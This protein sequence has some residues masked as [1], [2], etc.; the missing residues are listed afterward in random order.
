MSV[1]I[2]LYNSHKLNLKQQELQESTRE[3]LRIK[4]AEMLLKQWLMSLD[5]Y[6]NNRQAYIYDSLVDQGEAIIFL[7]NQFKYKYRLRDLNEKI[8]AVL[9]LCS[10]VH[11]PGKKKRNENDWYHIITKSDTITEDLYA[12]L[13]LYKADLVLKIDREKIKIASRQITLKRTLYIC[14]TALIVFTFLM[15]KWSNRTIV[16]P[17]KLLRVLA[18]KEEISTENFPYNNPI[19]LKSLADTLKQYVHD[20]EK[21]KEL[22]WL[23]TKQ[24]E[25]INMRISSIMET[26][27]DAIICSKAS[28]QIF[29]MNASFRDLVNIEQN[30]SSKVYLCQDFISDINLQK[31][32]VHFDNKKVLPE[33]NILSGLNGEKIKIELSVSK[34][35]IDENVFY[36]IIIRDV[37]ERERMQAQLLQS[38]KMDSIGILASGIAHEIN[39]PIQY[40][41]NYCLFL[42]D[43]YK[44]ILKYLE[45]TQDLDL[46]QKKRLYDEMDLDFI[47]TEIPV[48]LDGSLEGLQKV[49]DIVKSMKIMAH[50][51]KAK[52]I[53]Y[54]IN[55]LIKEAVLLSEN[56]WKKY[57]IVE[58]LLDDEIPEIYCFPGFLSQTFINIIINASHA[59]EAQIKK[60]KIETNG[61]ITITSKLKGQEI[62]IKFIDTG[63][64]INDKIRTKIFDPFFTTK[65]IGVGT[66]QGL[67]LS[68]D[69]I[70]NKHNGSINFTS[71]SDLGCTFV[72][73]L[74]IQ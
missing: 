48:A 32:N 59:I 22:A 15:I 47:N 71:N 35:K 30:D 60:Q 69:F 19:E 7:N 17:I 50:P 25:H 52:K 23:K 38:Q 6:L 46:E 11:Q 62:N 29:A 39:T 1:G 5:L 34:F 56:E 13:Q 44:D 4:E 66:G 10:E 68:H 18:S 54:D 49:S 20:L 21:A 45:L 33:Q 42:Q 43:A 57:A 67:A 24:V 31:Y 3:E 74:P 73:T 40:V 27:A 28:G 8:S 64:G 12:P 72:I 53:D 37:R 61:K 51:S 70:V 65:D 26:A 63:T 58:L 41:S 9:D 16:N 2:V 55:S 14:P 36:T